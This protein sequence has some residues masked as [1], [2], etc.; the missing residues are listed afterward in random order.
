MEANSRI[1]RLRQ[2]SQGAGKKKGSTKG[3][4][5]RDGH[6]HYCCK[7]TCQEVLKPPS[8]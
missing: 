1:E 3:P 5:G 7:G 6:V 4:Q 2:K 8:G